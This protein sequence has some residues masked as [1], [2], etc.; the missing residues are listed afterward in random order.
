MK[1]ERLLLIDVGNSSTT[2]A[3]Q[4]GRNRLQREKR[5]ETP[6]FPSFL[7]K[8][9]DESNSDPFSCALIASV[10]PK[11]TQK[12]KKIAKKYGLEL[13][14]V[15]ENLQIPLR[16]RYSKRQLGA[17]RLVTA[18]GASRLYG[19]PVLV[20]DYGTALTCDLVSGKGI[21]EGGLIVPGAEI[22]LKALSEKAAL[23]PRLPSFP[24]RAQS[25]LGRN[26][27]EGMEA[28]ILYGY[29]ALVEGL[30]TQFKKRCGR[31]LKVVA[32]GG[33]CRILAPYTPQIK[34]CDPLLTLRS[35][36]EIYRRRIPS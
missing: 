8:L 36:A 33:L 19:T 7:S 2:W 35:L 15:G 24:K 4:R 11:I 13:R 12:L 26:T 25:L 1:Q 14:I 20:L 5:I 21:F 17:D 9:I 10:V 6:G 31:A 29:G 18:Y 23:L 32:T 27:R 30:I 16:S 22:A 3:I 28:G 34:I